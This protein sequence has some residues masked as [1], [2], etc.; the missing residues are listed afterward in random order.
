[1]Y[2]DIPID[3]TFVKQLIDLNVHIKKISKHNTALRSE[4]ESMLLVNNIKDETVLEMYSDLSKY[5]G[6]L[7]DK[8]QELEVKIISMQR[9][10]ERMHEAKNREV[11]ESTNRRAIGLKNFL[12]R[13]HDRN[14]T[15]RINLE[16]PTYVYL[17]ENKSPGR[18]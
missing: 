18:S 12:Y 1:V 8:C 11:L 16:D 6:G 9:T 2:Q 15:L 3:Q 17:K 10:A 4:I 5:K 7:K 14:L 13:L